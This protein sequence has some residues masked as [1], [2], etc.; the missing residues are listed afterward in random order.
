VRRKYYDDCSQILSEHLL[1]AIKPSALT[2]FST[3]DPLVTT[4]LNRLDEPIEEKPGETFLSRASRMLQGDITDS[5][6]EVDIDEAG[7]SSV[8]NTDHGV[9]GSPSRADLEGQSVL[10][11][12]T[13]L[14]GALP[15]RDFPD[16]LLSEPASLAQST[17]SSVAENNDLRQK[18]TRSPSISHESHEEELRC[19]VS[20]IRHGDRT[21]K[22]KL[23]LNMSEPHIL[24]YFHNQ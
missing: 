18:K 5:E 23:K 21:P 20:I 6:D 11:A 17:N 10:A 2:T 7:Q 14:E 22:Q 1:A 4:S 8:Q 12:T 9:G 16:N 13:L 24:E 3:L 19:V 15:V